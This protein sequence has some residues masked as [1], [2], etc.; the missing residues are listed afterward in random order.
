VVLGEHIGENGRVGVA[1][2][3][4]VVYIV[5][6]CGDVEVVFVHNGSYINVGCSDTMVLSAHI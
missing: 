5:N 1:D 2:V 4:D 6:R 3:G